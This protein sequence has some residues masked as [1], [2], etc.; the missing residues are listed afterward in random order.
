MD[1]NITK[2]S[3]KEIADI[4]I[5]YNIIQ[6]NELRNHTRNQ[7]IGEIQKWV[8]YKKQSY[9]QRRHSSPNINMNNQVKNINLLKQNTDYEL[10]VVFMIQYLHRL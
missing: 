4:C 1:I 8:Q 10:Q 3:D 6:S 7:V 5:K 9:K 2:L